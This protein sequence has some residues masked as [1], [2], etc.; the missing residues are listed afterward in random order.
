MGVP[1]D[2]GGGEGD[3]AD[4]DIAWW[5]TGHGGMC[6]DHLAPLGP[7][8]DSIPIFASCSDPEVVFLFGVQI[9]DGYIGVVGIDAAVVDI[10]LAGKVIVQGVIHLPRGDVGEGVVVPTQGYLGV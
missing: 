7:L 2:G 6:R 9:G 10:L 8:G 1:F 4:G 5:D 3:V